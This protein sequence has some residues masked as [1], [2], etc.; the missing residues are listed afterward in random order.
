MRPVVSFPATIERSTVWGEFTLAGW[1]AD[2]AVRGIEPAGGA[3]RTRAMALV[4]LAAGTVAAAAVGLHWS[5]AAPWPELAVLGALALVAQLFPVHVSHAHVSLGVGFL[6][7]ACLAAGPEAG[8]VT[9]AA[10]LLAWSVAR[11]RAP[12]FRRGRGSSWRLDIARS[13]FVAGT[14]AATY[15]AAA[16]LAFGIFDLQA[17]VRAVSIESI[18]ASVVLA[19]GVYL[20]QH[21][22]SLG[23]ALLSGDD[24]V[25][26]LRTVI[27]M[28]AL[29]EFLALPAA[30]LLTVTAVQLGPTAF[31]L[32]A[33]LY[34]MAAFLG[35]R[36]WQ[37]RETITQRLEDVELLHRVGGLLSET[38]ELGELVRRL[39]GIL[40]EVGEFRAMLL[41]MDDGSERLSQLYAFDGRGRRS[42]VTT[43]WI[44]DTQARPEGLFFEPDGSAVFTRDLAVG[45]GATVRLRLDFR[46]D[47]LPGN[48][49]LV[50]I[51]TICR[52]AGTALSNARLYRLANTD[53]LTGVA[54]RR[55][56]ER[57][58]R[59]T[60]AR[61]EPFATIMLDLD[62]FKQVNDA[63]GHRVGDLVL[64]DLAGALTGSLRALDVAAR[65]G[66]EEFVILLPGASS[67]E[68]AGAAERIRRG[69]EHRRLSFEGR[70]VRYTAS[71]GVA[72]STDIDDA[73]DPMEVV[74][75]ADAALLEAKR[76]GRNQVVTYQAI[77]TRVLDHVEAGAVP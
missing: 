75:K 24:V 1:N 74:W 41:V 38:L 8:A 43:G 6:L 46:A 35:W 72:A 76:A 32:L 19:V 63:F 48:P 50:L 33:W 66:G 31:A 30:L 47:S 57:A 45:D 69:L 70:S 25:G 68:A 28:P 77:S 10:V 56:F 9:V 3:R 39:H 61:G 12:W 44:E 73:T 65:Y 71:F 23:V 58:L 5:P 18:G 26:H 40:C 54:I 52:Q 62:W 36:S 59:T 22:F 4:G 64:Q 21:L 11:A 42:E 60:A 14:G 15:L 49:Q 51:E 2:T 13:V 20:L 34:L 37:D 27:P 7:A 16:R 29:A 67:P 53:P 17:P 55:Y